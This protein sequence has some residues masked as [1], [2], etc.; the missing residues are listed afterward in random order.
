[1]KIAL[2]AFIALLLSANSAWPQPELPTTIPVQPPDAA[3][4][5]TP[6]APPAQPP[7]PQ[8][9]QAQP[10]AQAQAQ[11]PQANGHWVYNDQYG[12]VFQTAAPDQPPDNGHWAYSD[13]Y[14]WVFL[15]DMPDQPQANGQWVYTAQ[16]S[17]IWMPYGAQYVYEPPVAEAYPLSY[18]YY[19]TYG[20]VWV[21]APWVWGW[22]VVPFYGYYGPWHF[23]WYRG[24]TYIHPG[25]GRYYR[26][27]SYPPGRVV[28]PSVAVP[29]TSVPVPHGYR[30]GSGPNYHPATTVNQAG[31]RSGVTMGSGVR[32]GGKRTCLGARSAR[33]RPLRTCR[34]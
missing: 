30:S 8:E 31:Y 3:P 22:G 25:W 17:W 27:G 32:G 26:G 15:T 7:V 19:P 33:D 14:G 9:R 16:Y 34:L 21:E 10:E 23:A 12:W 2:L 5:Q 28:H 4:A 13:Q 20:W 24:P 6:P 11:Q 18:V 1:M 29:H